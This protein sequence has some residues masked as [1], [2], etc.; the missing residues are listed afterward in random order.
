MAR[1]IK[2][3]YSVPDI[4]L[5]SP[6]IR[7]LHTATVFARVLELPFENLHIIPGIYMGGEKFLDQLVRSLDDTKEAAMI[8][9][10]NPDFTYFANELL[11]KP[12]GNMPTTGTVSISFKTNHWAEVAK[13]LV[14]HENFDYPKKSS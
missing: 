14:A 8:F 12:I 6:A 1:K 7:A 3:K 5:T 9:G 13:S 4:I 2:S 11:T 10:H